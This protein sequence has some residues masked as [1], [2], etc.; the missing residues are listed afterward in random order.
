M[1]ASAARAF[2]PEAEAI[3]SRRR[4]APFLKW[5]GGKRQLLPELLGRLPARISG[6][7]REPFLGGGALFFALAAEGRI[8]RA[9]LCDVNAHLIET[10]ESVRDQ[11]RSLLLALSEHRND[12]EHYYRVRAQDP[13]MLSKVERAARFIYLNRCGFNGLYRVNSRGGFNVPFGRYVNPKICNPEALGA[14]ARALQLAELRVG[15]FETALAGAKRG[16]FVYF[17]PPY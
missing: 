4:P 9:V 3:S 15:D 10:Y 13:A 6:V 2:V 1:T 5:A 14:A 16:D 11:T 17:D 8:R 7:Y 12:R